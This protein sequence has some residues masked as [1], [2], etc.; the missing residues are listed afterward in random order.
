MIAYIVCIQGYEYGE[1]IIQ[2]I[3]INKEK[4]EKYC[5]KL[6]GKT[7]LKVYIEKVIVNNDIFEIEQ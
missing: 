2:A 6:Q 7:S 3:T 4:A 1:P 5:K